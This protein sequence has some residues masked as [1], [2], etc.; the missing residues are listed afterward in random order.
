MARALSKTTL[1]AIRF[2]I[3]N[4]SCLFL[5]A[6][7]PLLFYLQRIAGPFVWPMLALMSM[8]YLN[9]AFVII[10]SASIRGEQVATLTINMLYPF[11]EPRALKQAVVVSAG[12][13]L[14]EGL[15][16]VSLTLGQAFNAF[17]VFLIPASV[18]KMATEDNVLKAINPYQLIKLI[19]SLHVQYVLIWVFIGFW[20]L[21]VMLVLSGDSDFSV[22]LFLLLC[23]VYS[24]CFFMGQIVAGR[25]DRNQADHN[26]S[27]PKDIDLDQ[28]LDEIYRLEQVDQAKQACHDLELAISQRQLTV[29]DLHYL[30]SEM[31]P[32]PYKTVFLFLADRYLRELTERALCDELIHTV[33]ELRDIEG[34][35]LKIQSAKVSLFLAQSLIKKSRHDEAEKL[36]LN[37]ENNFPKSTLLPFALFELIKLYAKDSSRFELMQSR[38][39][40]FLQRY[41]HHR[42]VAELSS[43]TAG[44]S[45]SSA[46]EKK[47]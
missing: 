8:L 9:Y 41:S 34:D 30:Y 14:G 5:V 44:K 37:F 45:S 24:N 38:R 6:T 20:A 2:P 40:E 17:A 21:P 26:Y 27:P 22:K 11:N 46:S 29:D 16:A 33:D 25:W 13:A 1:L 15:A 4:P 42:L 35:G 19:L 47:L 43:L 7:I 3:F 23:A 39:E 28:L 12:F 32:W 18:M 10:D 31:K 36:L